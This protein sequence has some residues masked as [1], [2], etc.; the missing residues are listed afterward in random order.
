MYKN[1][2]INPTIN[3]V[4]GK[5][6]SD[7]V[8]S[9]VTETQES[10]TELDKVIGAD[11]GTFISSVSPLLMNKSFDMIPHVSY[12][13]LINGCTD[14]FTVSGTRYVLSLVPEDAS[15]ILFFKTSAVVVINNRYNTCQFFSTNIFQKIFF[16]CI[17]HTNKIF[18]NHNS[19]T[20]FHNCV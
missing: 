18:G 6:T 3:Y 1:L 10:I 14:V 15:A 2:E 12:G 4:D 8:D 20:P 16:D 5:I 7:S 17:L 13:V 9:I 11:L 19:Q